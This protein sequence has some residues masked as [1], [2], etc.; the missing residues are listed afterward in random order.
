MFN[1]FIILKYYHS[2]MS[3]WELDPQHSIIDLINSDTED[4]VATVGLK[5]TFKRDN[6]SFPCLIEFQVGS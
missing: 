2:V 4:F 5:V 3:K 6:L 1:I